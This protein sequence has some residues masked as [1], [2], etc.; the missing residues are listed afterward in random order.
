MSRHVTQPKYVKGHYNAPTDIAGNSVCTLKG[1]EYTRD[2]LKDHAISHGYIGRVFDEE[3]GLD[4][5]WVR[6]LTGGNSDSEILISVYGEVAGCFN[7]NA[8]ERHYKSLMTQWDYQ[9]V[10][11]GFEPTKEER[12][13]AAELEC[14]VSDVV[15]ER[16]KQ[17]QK[18]L[19]VNF[20]NNE[21]YAVTHGAQ[22]LHSLVG[23][24]HSDIPLKA[25][26][27]DEKNQIYRFKTGPVVDHLDKN[28]SNNSKFNLYWS[29]GE[30]NTV[31]ID[32][33]IEQK[34]QFYRDAIYLD[35]GDREQLVRR[36]N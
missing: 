4:C 11:S 23:I 29:T 21:I 25:T 9:F 5:Y 12:E 35:S 36:V 18:Y 28:K 27:W 7:L 20:N 19:M 31:M 24:T 13:L 3:D 33:T 26:W 10:P 2:Q 34:R 22:R 6:Y 15:L 14:S 32:W 17:T 8:E 30:Q 1:G 16:V